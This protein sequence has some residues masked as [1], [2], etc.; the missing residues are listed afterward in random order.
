M[1]K[2]FKTMIYPNKKQSEKIIKF[3]NGSRF[4]YNWSIALEQENYKNGGKL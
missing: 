2:G 3:C 4:C 1:I